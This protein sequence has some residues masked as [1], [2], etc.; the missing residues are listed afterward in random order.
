MESPAI[1]MGDKKKKKISKTAKRRKKK[2]SRLTREGEGRAEEEEDEGPASRRGK[3][4]GRGPEA[5]LGFSSYGKN[6]NFEGRK[7]EKKNLTA[8]RY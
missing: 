4:V 6:N 3:A 8:T 5:P 1:S 7:K 2:R